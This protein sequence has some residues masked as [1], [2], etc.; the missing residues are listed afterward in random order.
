MMTVGLQVLGICKLI[1]PDVVL[2]A[3]P[4]VWTGYMLRNPTTPRTT[5]KSNTTNTNTT[6][7]LPPFHTML[8]LHQIIPVTIEDNFLA[9]FDTAAIVVCKFNFLFLPGGDFYFR[10]RLMAN[11]PRGFINFIELLLFSKIGCLVVT[12]QGL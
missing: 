10:L 2:F 11:F 5:N 4:N 12:M 1:T 9:G 3:L 7:T 6:T 8:V